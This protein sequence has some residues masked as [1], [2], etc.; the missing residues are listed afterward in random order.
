MKRRMNKKMNRR[1][2]QGLAGIF[3]SVGAFMLPVSGYA[4]EAAAAGQAQPAVAQAQEAAAEKNNAAAPVKYVMP[5]EQ[6]Y[7]DQSQVE[8]ARQQLEADAFYNANPQNAAPAAGTKAEVTKPAEQAVA[9]EE[10][11]IE[12]AP[13]AQIEA[14]AAD[15]SRLNEYVSNIDTDKIAAE[16]YLP[17]AEVETVSVENIGVEEKMTPLYYDDYGYGDYAAVMTMEATAYLPT[18]GDGYGITATGIP[19]T[20]GVAAVDPSVIPLGSRLY[21]PGYGEAIAADTGGAIY[22]YRIDLCMEDYWQA[23]DFGRRT[24]TVFVLK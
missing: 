3:L 7:L 19:A 1:V 14:S 9:A 13:V 10:K 5:Q 15:F 4:E 21:V 22:G 2:L 6:V 11:K 20:Y 12:T 17:N 24:V 16:A 23:M 18:D 8:A